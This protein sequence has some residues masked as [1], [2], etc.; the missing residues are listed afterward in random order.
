V[1]QYTWD[2]WPFLSANNHGE[3]IS[4]LAAMHD[5]GTLEQHPTAALDLIQQP[6]RTP[7]A[8]PIEQAAFETAP[9]AKAVN[10]ARALEEGEGTP[11]G[12]AVPGKEWVSWPAALHCNLEAWE[13]RAPKRKAAVKA[14]QEW[15]ESSSSSEQDEFEESPPKKSKTGRRDE[16]GGEI[17]EGNKS[18]PE[19]RPPRL[20]D[21]SIP[22][23]EEAQ[24]ARFL[25]LFHPASSPKSP[26]PRGRFHLSPS[27]RKKAPASSSAFDSQL[28]QTGMLNYVSPLKAPAVEQEAAPEESPRVLE[29]RRG[30]LGSGEGSGEA[31]NGPGPSGKLPRGRRRIVV[32]LSSEHLDSQE[33]KAAHRRGPA[34]TTAHSGSQTEVPLK[35]DRGVGPGPVRGSGVEPAGREEE[36]TPLA[37]RSPNRGALSRRRGSKGRRLVSKDE[38]VPSLEKKQGEGEEAVVQHREDGGEPEDG[39][40][41]KS[42]SHSEEGGKEEQIPCAAKDRENQ[43]VE[44]NAAEVLRAHSQ[45]EKGPDMGRKWTP[46]AGTGKRWRKGTP[47]FHSNGFEDFNGAAANRVEKSPAARGDDNR[48]RGSQCRSDCVQVSIFGFKRRAKQVGRA[49][50]ER[51]RG[52]HG[53]IPWGHRGIE[54]APCG[55]DPGGGQACGVRCPGAVAGGAGVRVWGAAAALSGQ[56]REQHGA[57]GRPAGPAGGQAQVA[58]ITEAVSGESKGETHWGLRFAPEPGALEWEHNGGSGAGELW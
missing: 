2:N 47:F 31:A 14:R 32:D 8:E 33:P 30:S 39:E 38:S 29:P 13:D 58:G 43:L 16:Q 24:A 45:G 55:G 12:R 6:A 27:P 11:E 20:R 35:E 51:G 48:H 21:G 46:P 36:N 34:E 49:G 52:Q 37:L 1:Q 50:E 56:D 9:Q 18:A 23:E 15:V 44:E 26:K 25:S 19:L 54:V 3:L 4:I 10:Q 42:R 28:K 57:P 40:T 5:S 22:P 17:K 53:R 41:G 7:S